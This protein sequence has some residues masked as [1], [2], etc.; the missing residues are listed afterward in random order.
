MSAGCAIFSWSPSTLDSLGPTLYVSSIAV[1]IHTLF[2][3][4]FLVFPSLRQ[5]NMMWL[6]IYLITDFLLISRFFILY[7][8][9]LAI[10]CLFPTPRNVLCYFEA[11]SKFYINTVQTYLLL[12]FNVCRYKQIV[13]NRNIYL[14]RP[15][16]I[17]LA[18]V[19]IYILPVVNII[20]QFLTNLSQIRRRR[21]GS[22]DIIYSSTIVQIFNLFV[23]YI[24]PVFLNIII[25]GLGIRYVSSVKGVV[26]TQIIRIRRKR[27]R[28]LVL[29]TLV[30]YSIW[31]LLWSPDVL[32]FQF[33]NVNSDPA[34]VTSLL[35]YM[36]IALDP[37]LIAIV[38]IR[39]LTTWRT[40]YNKM[41]RHRQIGAIS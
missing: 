16:L 6:Y 4:Q 27:Q 41:K 13:S 5:R 29:Q 3:I 24:I 37:A 31:C 28:V 39:F 35:S 12:A 25:L 21:G 7:G 26:S 9:R 22:C 33:I 23:I 36:E 40:L 19:L 1:A 15:R 17:V 18:H 8:I 11:A 2:W 38:D 14:E 30:F 34:I 10:A 20:V 32:S